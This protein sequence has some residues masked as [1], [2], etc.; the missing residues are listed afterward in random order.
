MMLE[1]KSGR[2]IFCSSYTGSG[3]LGVRSGTGTK[4]GWGFG[5]LLGEVI[6]MVLVGCGPP[7]AFCGS[8]SS[9][10]MFTIR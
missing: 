1:S 8:A 10:L 7:P 6:S 9:G 3:S 4:V 5:T 2:V